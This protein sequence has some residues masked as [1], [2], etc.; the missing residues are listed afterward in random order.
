MFM[1]NC[2]QVAA[3]SSEVSRSLLKRRLLREGVVLY[4]TIASPNKRRLSRLRD[5]SDEYAATCQQLVMN[6]AGARLEIRQD[7]PGITPQ[8][9]SA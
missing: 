1:T 8:C 2:W 9:R 6:I 4:R 7:T 5:T 3:Y